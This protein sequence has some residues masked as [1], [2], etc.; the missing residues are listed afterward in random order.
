MLFLKS[1]GGNPRV[2]LKI[3]LIFEPAQNG[4]LVLL[5]CNSRIIQCHIKV[6]I[7]LFLYSR[8]SFKLKSENSYLAKFL[9]WP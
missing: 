9:A 2:K 5:L 8:T 3:L 1:M 6:T 4:M 7:R